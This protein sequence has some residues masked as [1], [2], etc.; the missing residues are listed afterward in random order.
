MMRFC[1]YH[2][3]PS[4][5][6]HHPSI[7]HHPSSIPHALAPSACHEPAP[8][9]CS[10]YVCMYSPIQAISI[11]LYNSKYPNWCNKGVYIHTNIYIYIYLS[12]TCEG[13]G[14]GEGED[15]NQ[16]IIL[17]QIP[18]CYH[19]CSFLLCSISSFPIILLNCCS[20]AVWLWRT[21]DTPPGI[22]T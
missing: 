9:T 6:I 18:W 7:I 3:H 19:P 22:V 4:N 1:K 2:P 12:I 20:L 21:T 8:A 16:P 5:N 14:E 17:L 11:V 15:E 13:E 10:L